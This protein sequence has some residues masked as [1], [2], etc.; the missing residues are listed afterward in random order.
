MKAIHFH[1]LIHNFFGIRSH[2]SEILLNI[3]LYGI[4]WVNLDKIKFYMKGEI[5][6]TIQ[7]IS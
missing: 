3:K 1:M 4:F 5:C 7:E 2:N 6:E